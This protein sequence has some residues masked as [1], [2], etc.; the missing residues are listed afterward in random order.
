MKKIINK[1]NIIAAA[2]AVGIYILIMLLCSAGLLSRHYQSLLVPIGINVILAVSL[3]LTVGFLGELTLGHAG[4][5]SVGAYAGCLFTLYSD[6]PTV[7]ELPL[8]II[9]GGAVAAVFGII[10]GI[11][12]LRLKGDYLAIVTLAFGE[13]IRSVI[14]NLDALGGAGG[15]KGIDKSSGFTSVYIL[16]LITVLVSVTL[17]DSRHGRAITAIRDNVIA[18]ESIG[19]NVVFYK[20]LAFVSAAFFAGAAGVLYGHNLGILK[21]N[22][23]DF[24]KSIEI[25]V[26]VV[27]GGMGSIKGSIISA[28]II[29]LLPEV[30]RGLDD[31]RM[32]IYSIV[33]IAIMI[34]NN[35][36]RLTAAKEKFI[37]KIR[38]G[39]APA[40]E[41]A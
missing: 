4:F 16:L 22:T 25:L 41:D 35:S 34:V 23:F 28:V 6:L 2:V 10:I 30:L 38:S 36:R 21:P 31:Y 33:L 40:K 12:A 37:E 11:P 5:M 26:I 7:I 18:A 39:N 27:L 20:L 17:V 13:I 9:I 24:N 15:L 1:K 29:T 8:A 19:I 3:N 14:T 32:L